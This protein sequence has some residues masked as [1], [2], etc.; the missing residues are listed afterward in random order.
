M[1]QK[2]K[3]TGKKVLITAGAQ[4]IGESITKH[5]IDSGAHVAIHYFSSADTAKQLTTYATSNGVNAVAIS[6]D[7]TKETDVNALIEKTAKALGGIDILIN[8][9]GSLV[10]RK[11]LSEMETDFWNKVMAINLTS[12]MLV[13]RAAAPYLAKNNN[14][15]IVNLAS[16]AGRKGGHPGSLAYATSKGAILTYT[17]ALSTELGPQG[18]RVNAV[19]PGLILGTSFHD[20][21]TTKDSAAA[22]IA[23]IPVQRAGNADD[24]ARAVLYLASEYDGFITGATLDINGGVYNM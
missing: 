2:T 17:R 18:T 8:N 9:A 23:G 3:L 16:L 14:S 5:F 21:H 20:T 13:T 22:T 7:L 1:K 15:S 24:V 10:A 19:A 12:M 4:G 6:G 11:M